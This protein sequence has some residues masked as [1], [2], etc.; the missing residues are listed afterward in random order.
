MPPIRSSSVVRTTH[1]IRSS[2]VVHTTHVIRSSGVVRTTHVMAQGLT[3]K[4][5]WKATK[6]ALRQQKQVRRTHTCP[7]A[8]GSNMNL[9]I[10]LRHA[11]ACMQ[12]FL[13][14]WMD[15]G[16]MDGFWDGRSD[17]QMDFWTPAFQH[18]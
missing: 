10:D 14:G 8:S 16:W 4:E 11:Y 17:G 5:H 15:N 7:H 6:D 2:G 9:L 1:V 12:S 3:W 18:V 13:D